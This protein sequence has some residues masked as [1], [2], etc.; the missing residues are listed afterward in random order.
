MI[1]AQLGNVSLWVD[2]MKYGVDHSYSSLYPVLNGDTPDDS[3]SKLPYEK[4]YQFLTYLE[5]LIGVDDFQNFVRTY[6]KKYSL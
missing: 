3:F 4:G 5:T 2:I 1:E 6:I